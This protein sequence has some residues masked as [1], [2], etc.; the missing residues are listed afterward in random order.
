ME[1]NN[2]SNQNS[3]NNLEEN[4]SSSNFSNNLENE[5]NNLEADK[6]AKE[7]EKY[8]QIIQPPNVD[9]LNENP[10]IWR[11][12]FG[13]RLGAYLIDGVFFFLLFLIFA[14]FTEVTDRIMDMFGS[15]ID[16]Y[17]DPN[18]MDEITMGMVLF[19]NETFIPLFLA[20]T[21]IYHSLEVIF[22]QSIGKMLLGIKIGSED[23]KNASYKQ[24][25]LRYAL[26]N[27]SSI[28]SLL[29]LI[30]SLAFM[31]TL[32]TITGVVFFIG[33]FFVLSVKKQ[34][35]YDTISKTAVYFKDELEQFN[36]AN[37]N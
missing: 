23:K 6:F 34:A 7:Q 25:L 31:N 30:T 16:M 4:G 18:K 37:N 15:D 28:F 1:E 32:G 36:N 24:L 8:K 10:Y 12:G 11:I 3:K 14:V 35:L 2:N 5:K 22:A 27:S 20:V 13:R 19:I 33:C 17:S 9:V 26:K 29:A 21:F